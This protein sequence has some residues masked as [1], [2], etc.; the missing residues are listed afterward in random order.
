LEEEM[1]KINV[2]G[3][4]LAYEEL[5]QGVPLVLI[6]GY[7][8]DHTVWDK[9]ASLLG[10]EFHLIMP[11]LRGFGQSEAME[12]DASIIE[13]ASD[14]KDLLNHLMIKKAFLAGHSMG[15]YVALAFARK[16]PEAVSGLALISSQAAADSPE[17]KEGRYATAKQVLNEGVSVVAEAMTPKLST[18]LRIQS[19]VRELISKQRPLGISSALT[20]MAKRPD[21]TELLSSFLFPFVIVHGAADV[22]IPIERGREMKATL[23]SAHFVELPNTGHMP[24]MENPQSVAEALHLFVK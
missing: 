20:A 5:G 21:S 11:D 24:M 17:R 23:P 2:A 19:F 7:P 22:L 13:Y 14:I 12:I 3:I 10:K 16:Y 6:H 4:N 18:D 8:L 1:K 9:V 15:G